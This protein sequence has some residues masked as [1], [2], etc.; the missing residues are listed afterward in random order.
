MIYVIDHI[1]AR[2]DRRRFLRFQGTWSGVG[3]RKM[4]PSCRGLNS[5]EFSFF[6]ILPSSSGTRDSFSGVCIKIVIIIMGFN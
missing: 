3:H 5:D 2:C 6:K 1:N 4:S